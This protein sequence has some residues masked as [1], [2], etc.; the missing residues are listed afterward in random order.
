[1][2]MP[3]KP[4]TLKISFGK[5]FSDARKQGLSTFTWTKAQGG[6]G[7][8]FSTKTKE[9]VGKKGTKKEIGKLKTKKKTAL[10]KVKGFKAKSKIRKTFRKAKKSTKANNKA[11]RGY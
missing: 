5:R 9:E 6:N 4:K 2:A 1:M 8:R 10:K 11:L 3:V 7:K